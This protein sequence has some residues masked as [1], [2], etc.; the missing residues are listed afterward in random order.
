MVFLET[1]W[2]EGQHSCLSV[3][4]WSNVVYQ[5]RK[6]IQSRPDTLLLSDDNFRLD[7]TTISVIIKE[8]INALSYLMCDLTVWMCLEATRG[9]LQRTDYLTMKKVSCG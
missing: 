9:L 6:C 3:N 8:T 5:L 2:K 4:V 7:G 1:K